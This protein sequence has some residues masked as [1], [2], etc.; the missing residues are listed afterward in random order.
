[1]KFIAYGLTG[2]IVLEV[3]AGIV[4]A[5]A[6]MPAFMQPVHLFLATLIF[7][8]QFY[9]LLFVNTQYKLNLVRNE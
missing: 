7:G 2:L 5:Y 4:L 6:G 8:L 9:A 1:M 3:L